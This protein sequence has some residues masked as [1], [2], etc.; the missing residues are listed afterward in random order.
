MDGL[1]RHKRETRAHCSASRADEGAERENA[2]TRI[3]ERFREDRFP[4]ESI[5]R[6]SIR[7]VLRDGC[8]SARVA[9]RHTKRIYAPLSIDA[10]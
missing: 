4:A 3:Y 8:E 2:H 5:L 10:Y 7:P 9:V 6:R 1:I